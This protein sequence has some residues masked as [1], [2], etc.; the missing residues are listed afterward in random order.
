[1]FMIVQSARRFAQVDFTPHRHTLKL[2]LPPLF[3]AAKTVRYRFAQ[4]R[5]F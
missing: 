2:V 4:K 1:M 3:A 5:G